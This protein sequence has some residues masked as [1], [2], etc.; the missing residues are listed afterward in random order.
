MRL[1]DPG[2]PLE[3]LNAVAPWEVFRKPPAK[4]LQRSDSAKGG[5]PLYDAVL[6]FKIMVLQALYSLS[7]SAPY[8]SPSRQSR[9]NR[10]APSR[11]VSTQGPGF[12][13][14]VG[15]G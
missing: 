1:S 13:N 6:M 2:D 4:V 5:R 12:V 9:C 10:V 11:A 8:S 3:K 7:V 14:T 15:F